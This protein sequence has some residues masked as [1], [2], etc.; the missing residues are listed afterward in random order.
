VLCLGSGLDTAFFR[1]DIGKCLW[2]D[3]DFPEVVELRRTLLPE[4]ER[5]RVLSGSVL[6]RETYAG[7]RLHGKV[8]VLAV[9]LLYYFTPAEIET[10][11]SLLSE[12]C[13]RFFMVAEVL[14][15]RGVRITNKRVVNTCAGTKATWAVRNGRD[16]ESLSPSLQ[17]K[18][19]YPLF[20]KIRPAMNSGQRRL[21]FIADL[22]RLMSFA[23]LEVGNGSAKSGRR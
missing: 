18:E 23:V 3:I 21:A 6:K 20:R 13:P 22:L 5:V 10:L 14:S 7:I 11:F 12:I 8:V 16:L 17:V 1:N 19:L 4:N 15:P 2:Y 9:G